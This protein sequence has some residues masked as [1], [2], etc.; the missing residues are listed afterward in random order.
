MPS[1][2]VTIMAKSPRAGEVKTRL[3]PPLSPPDAA[4]LYR[5]FLLDKIAQ[6]RA[7]AGAQAAIAYTPAED[8][9]VFQALA[10]GFL[11][12]PQRGP[13]LGARLADSL[14]QLLALGHAA[15]F[16]I[17]SDTPT[18]PTAYLA[19]ALDLIATPETDLVLGPSEDGGYYLIGLRTPHRELF[20]DMPWSTSQVVPETLRRAAAK[21]LT[22]ASLPSWFDID[23]PEDLERLRASLGSSPENA[24]RYTRQFFMERR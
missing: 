8:R 17:D 6:V 9:S 4:E 11:L 2:V 16:A 7:L 15:A 1:I 12:L 24:A 19:R 22:V 20:D 5:C 10:P 3:T 18:L 13:D 14:G 21:G 23:T